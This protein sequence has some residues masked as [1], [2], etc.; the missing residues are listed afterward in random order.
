M[1]PNTGFIYQPPVI[2]KDWIFG[3][4]LSVETKVGAEILQ[5]DGQWDSYLPAEERQSNSSFDTMS[6]VTFATLNCVEILTRRLWKEEKEFSDRF[7]SKRSGTTQTGN[8]PQT[9]AAPP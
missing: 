7:L 3:S 5:P 1:K 2:D 9:A 8:S 6:C 4:D